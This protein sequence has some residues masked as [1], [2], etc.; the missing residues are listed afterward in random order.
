MLVLRSTKLPSLLTRP[1]NEDDKKSNTKH[2]KRVSSCCRALSSRFG[3]AW[4]P[5]SLPCSSFR[6]SFI[7][8]S[9]WF[10]CEEVKRRIEYG[11]PA[12]QLG[13]SGDLP[14]RAALRVVVVARDIETGSLLCFCSNRS[15]C[16]SHLGRVGKV[17]EASQL[18]HL[19][20]QDLGSY[21]ERCRPYS[22]HNGN[23]MALQDCGFVT[24][25]GSV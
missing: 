1:E 2:S 23:C 5:K 13:R 10:Y 20:S 4:T 8:F 6:L 22:V 24:G 12:G 19:G 16:G 25:L 21:H 17:S 15:L 7:G 11:H 3:L 18:P 14:D 9:R